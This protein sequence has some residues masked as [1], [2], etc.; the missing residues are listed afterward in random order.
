MIGKI[1]FWLKPILGMV[2]RRV[3][4]VLMDSAL[5]AVRDVA[6]DYPQAPPADKRDMATD[7]IRRRL[8]VAGMDA[9]TQMVGAAIEMAVKRLKERGEVQ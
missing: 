3:G 2:F 5:E 7:L 4:R 8:I 6:R 9:S 1:L